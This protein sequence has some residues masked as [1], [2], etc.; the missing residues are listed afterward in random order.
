MDDVPVDTL[1]PDMDTALNTPENRMALHTLMG[2]NPASQSVTG[3]KPVVLEVRVSEQTSP[4]SWTAKSY[5]I[6]V[7]S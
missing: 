5:R 6:T 3:I 1:S 4:T 7:E 2:L